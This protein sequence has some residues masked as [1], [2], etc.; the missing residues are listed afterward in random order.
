MPYEYTL[1]LVIFVFGMFKM[2]DF[3][4]VMTIKVVVYL[5]FM[6]IVLLPY[7]HFLGLW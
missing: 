7:W 3:I 1:Y 4:K 2:S 6:A 5:I